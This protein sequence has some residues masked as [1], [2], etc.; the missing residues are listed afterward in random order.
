MRSRLSCWRPSKTWSL[1]DNHPTLMGAAAPFPARPASWP[2]STAVG[3]L[4]SDGTSSR[5][6]QDPAAPHQLLAQGWGLQP[7]RADASGT[8]A[9]GLS[10]SGHWGERLLLPV[11]SWN[12]STRFCL[13]LTSSSRPASRPGLWKPPVA[14]G[15]NPP[16]SCSRPN[17][18]HQ[19]LSPAWW[20]PPGTPGPGVTTGLMTRR[21][22]S[23]L[24]AG[25]P[26]PAQAA[27]WWFAAG[28]QWARGCGPPGVLVCRSRPGLGWRF[29]LWRLC[30]GVP[31]PGGSAAGQGRRRQGVAVPGGNSG[32][33]HPTA[34]TPTGF[35]AC[36]GGLAGWR[37]GLTQVPW[38]PWPPASG[39]Q[40]GTGVRRLSPQWKPL[41]PR[42]VSAMP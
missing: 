30:P 39:R 33:L 24:A 31:W 25:T 28:L 38:A 23:C 13:L 19:S 42:A 21:S 18:P 1:R 22:R 41:P 10:C 16:Q 9:L 6:T 27:A 4:G 3:G 5:A 17:C 12:P 35:L 2:R 20:G 14:T 8:A 34:C 32:P 15:L 11:P 40:T 26:E 36:C 29:G 7:A 37:Q